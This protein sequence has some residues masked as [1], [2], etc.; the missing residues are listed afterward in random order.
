VSFAGAVVNVRGVVQGVGFRWWCVRKAKE[1]GVNGYTA[2]LY[3]GSVEVAIE[4]DRGLIEG[5]VEVLKVGP[6]YAKVTD[7][8]ILWYDKPKGYKDF[9]IEYKD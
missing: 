5:F 6:T 3:D 7:I 4:G 9:T 8:K 1:F 2:N